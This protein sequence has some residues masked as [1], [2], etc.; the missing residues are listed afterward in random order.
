M[1]RR[2]PQIGPDGVLWTS[3]SPNKRWLSFDTKTHK[4][5]N[6]FLPEGKIANSNALAIN[7]TNGM[8]WAG[9]ERNS[10]YSLDTK[11]GEWS[12][13]RAPTPNSGAVVQLF[14]AAEG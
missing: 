10:I 4:F 1:Q 2:N 13:Y 7:R 8:I 6:Y 5:I 12:F 11:T 3:D 14:A 9:D